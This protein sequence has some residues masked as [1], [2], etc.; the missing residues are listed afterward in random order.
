MLENDESLK[1]DSFWQKWQAYSLSFSPKYGVFWA[2]FNLCHKMKRV[3]NGQFF[4]KNGKP[5]AL[6]FRQ[7]IVFFGTF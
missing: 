2:L 4:G 5:I 6:L 1:M 3:E 7:N